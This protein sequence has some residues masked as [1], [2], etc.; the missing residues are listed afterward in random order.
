MLKAHDI[1]TVYNTD[2]ND[3]VAQGTYDTTDLVKLS[4]YRELEAK[5][6]PPLTFDPN[7][8]F[9]SI[10]E[11]LDLIYAQPAPMQALLAIVEANIR[12]GESDF[13]GSLVT[14]Y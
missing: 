10:Q 14:S 12:M 8:G 9:D 4:K 1:Y 5:L 3:D 11:A 7:R 13:A 2:I 6:P